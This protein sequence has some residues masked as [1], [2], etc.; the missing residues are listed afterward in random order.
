MDNELK[1]EIPVKE[2]LEVSVPQDR[3]AVKPDFD[4]DGFL[5][6][7]KEFITKVNAIMVDKQDYHII[8][9]K[10]SLAKGGAEKIASIFSWQAK[11]TKDVEAFEML[12]VKGIVAFVCN[13][14]KNGVFVGQG[15]GASTL[16]KNAGDPNKT[17]KMA[18]KSAYVDA[19]I[20][21]SG[22]SDFFTQD[23]EDMPAGT[24]QATAKPVQGS[25]RPPVTPH[26]TGSGSIKPSTFQLDTIGRMIRE[27][28]VSKQEITDFIKV[29]SVDKLTGG[30]EGTASRLI[31]WLI[32]YRKE[33]LPV[34]Q[35]ADEASR[36][37]VEA[38]GDSIKN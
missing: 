6:K 37:E 33:D 32:D 27:K 8:Q 9:G 2:S 26:P 5:A 30:R 1:T 22:L 21:S 3:Q 20:R 38:I 17:I 10:K 13:L 7:R 31:G 18:Q 4:I 36:R 23:L 12:D 16:A 28:N 11:F 29:D 19:V 25:Y 35:Q 34:I 24:V 14:E 15:R